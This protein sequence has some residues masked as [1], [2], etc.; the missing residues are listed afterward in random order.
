LALAACLDTT[1]QNAGP[2]NE[3]DISCGV[4]EGAIRQVSDGYEFRTSSNHCS[5]GVFNQR[6]E[7]HTENFPTNRTGAFLFSSEI[8]MT[9]PVNRAFSIFSI[10]DGRDGCAPPLQLFVRPDGRM[11]IASDIKTGSGQS[12]IEGVIGGVS[13]GRILRDGTDQL[14]EILVQFDGAG[15]FGVTVTLD[16]V[17]QITGRYQPSSNSAAILSE[18]FYFKHGVYSRSV[19]D[20]LLRSSGMQVVAVTVDP[21]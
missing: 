3:W 15:G 4:D 14:L 19:F 7:I 2:L 8:A 21:S 1:T 10:H 16:G 11:Y 6:A 12:C 20:Y 17:Q 18:R 9:S 13:Q 5:G